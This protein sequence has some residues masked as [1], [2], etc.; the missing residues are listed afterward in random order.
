MA[1]LS[2]L[3]LSIQPYI[4]GEQPKDMQY[5]KLNTNENP[6]PPSSKVAQVLNDMDPAAFRLYPPPECEELRESIGK[7]YDVDKGCVYVANGS[8]ELLSWCFPAFFTGKEPILINDITYSFY[9]VYAAL[10]SV[11]T[12]VVPLNDDFS[13]PMEYYIGRNR[14]IIIANPNAPTG[15]A[16]S[17]NEIEEIVRSNPDQVVIIDEAYV[18][19]G[20]ESAVPLTKRY[21]NLLVVQTFSKSRSLAGLRCGFAIGSPLLIDGLSRIKNSLNSYTMDI[22]TLK[23]AKAAV[24]DADYFYETTAKVIST[25]NRVSE[26][27]REAGFE[28]ADSTANF[29]F[30]THPKIT[31]SVLFEK[32]RAQGILVRYF[33]LPRIDDYL[34]ITIG[35]DEQMDVLIQKLKDLLMNGRKYGTNSKS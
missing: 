11:K 1:Y 29:L 24:E 34:R 30:V 10:F 22:V 8:D 28:F 4:P 14:G 13:I 31:A 15:Q 3:A 33:N 23:L 5:I 2:D 27:L 26:K 35:R 7:F 12:E 18:D 20:C 32:L 9:K 6:Y 17:L 25:R 16:I 21:E 19:F